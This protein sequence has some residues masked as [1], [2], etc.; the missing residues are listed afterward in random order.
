LEEGAINDDYLIPMRVVAGGFRAVY[1]PSA[2]AWERDTASV[3]GEFARRRRIAAGNCQ[4]ILSLAKLLNP[5]RGWIAFSFFSHKV[6]RTLAPLVMLALFV[7]SLWLPQPWRAL[8][9]TAQAALYGCAWIG[10]YLQQ[11]GRLIRWLSPPL[12]FCAGN[13]AM[14]A[15]MAQFCVSRRPAWGRS[16]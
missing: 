16:R 13:L 10:Y 2:V 12:Y 9:V 8:A 1:E 11:R 6:L 5:L 3:K 15:G 4:Q 14:L 7:S